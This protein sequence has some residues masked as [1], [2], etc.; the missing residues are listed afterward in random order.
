MKKV[1]L[2][3]LAAILVFGLVACG[4]PAP[5]ATD[6][7]AAA[8]EAPAADAPAATEAPAAPA[9]DAGTP[10]KVAVLLKPLSNEYWSSMKTGVEAWAK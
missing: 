8:T 2:V 5:A 1:L 9:A 4:T 10:V 3:A 7:P 6:A